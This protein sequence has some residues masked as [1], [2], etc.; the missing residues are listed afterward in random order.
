MFQYQFHCGPIVVTLISDNQTLLDKVAV[1]LGQYNAMWQSSA[2]NITIT[3]SLHNGAVTAAAGNFMTCA[4]MNVDISPLGLYA[5]TMA[6]A[7]CEYNE[8]KGLWAVSLP[9]SLLNEDLGDL[10]EDFINLALTTSWRE[11]GWVPVHAASIIKDNCCVLLCASSGGGKTSLTASLIRK[12]WK[13]LGD[14]KLLIR[15]D[16]DKKPFAGALVHH[17]NLHPRSSDWFPEV[18]DLSLLPAYSRWTDKRK[19]TISSIWPNKAVINCMPTHLGEV[20]R[21]SDIQGIEIHPL[22]KEKILPI[23]LKQTVLPNDRSVA[24]KI[25]STIASVAQKL[26]GF[27]IEIGDNAYLEGADNSGVSPWVNK[28]EAAIL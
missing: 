24:G 28:L 8:S 26:K 14:D 12:G 22:T 13:T 21:R 15:I 5:S 6:G 18:G 9:S 3:F 1:S 4:R 7:C 16:E 17:F 25:V 27:R 11:L 19:V 20:V 10:L 23:L 2:K